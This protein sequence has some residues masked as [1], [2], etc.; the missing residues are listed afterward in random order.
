MKIIEKIRLILTIGLVVVLSACSTK[1]IVQPAK[2][3]FIA[4][5]NELLEHHPISRVENPSVKGLAEAYIENT[6]QL[7]NANTRLNRIKE[8]NDEQKRIYTKQN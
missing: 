5:P 2:T 6:M 4:I 1:P 8:W 3:V 7:G